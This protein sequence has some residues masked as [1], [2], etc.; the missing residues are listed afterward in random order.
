MFQVVAIALQTIIFVLIG[1]KMAG[2]LA[3]ILA[4]VGAV[5]EELDVVAVGVD[6]LVKTVADL[7][8]Q[9]AAGV[10]VAQADLD[11]LDAVVQSIQGKLDGVKAAED[12]ALTPVVPAP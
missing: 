6:T 8:A 4:E 3:S 2:T 5:N 11:A 7:K 10:P 12:A 1:V 9:L